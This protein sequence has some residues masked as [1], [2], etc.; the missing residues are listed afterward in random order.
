MAH[1]IIIDNLVSEMLLA[2][3]CHDSSQPEQWEQ[4]AR[5]TLKPQEMLK[6]FS[7]LGLRLMAGKFGTTEHHYGKNE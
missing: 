7:G 5:I 4:A 6:V 1:C 3:T 2:N